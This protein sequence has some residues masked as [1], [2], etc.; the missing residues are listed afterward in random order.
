MARLKEMK[1]GGGSDE[2]RQ[3]LAQVTRDRENAL[4]EVADLKKLLSEQN[5][6]LSAAAKAR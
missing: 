6:Q 2:V 4:Q 5:R 3:E 1:G